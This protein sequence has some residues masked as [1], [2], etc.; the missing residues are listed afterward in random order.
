MWVLLVLSRCQLQ[1]CTWRKF[2]QSWEFVLFIALSLNKWNCDNCLSMNAFLIEKLSWLKSLTQQTQCIAAIADSAGSG[3]MCAWRVQPNECWKSVTTNE[4]GR[5][6]VLLSFKKTNNH[7]LID[8][9]PN[10]NLH[11]ESQCNLICVAELAA[12]WQNLIFATIGTFFDTRCLDVQCM[13]ESNTVANVIF[14]F[15]LWVW[16]IC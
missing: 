8:W 15:M 6:R 12:C 5:C 3:H 1:K 9:L 10:N 2:L 13:M 16:V 4:V 14:V 7:H 11:C